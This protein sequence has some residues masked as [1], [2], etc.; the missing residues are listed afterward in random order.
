M[1]TAKA[2]SPARAH[3]ADQRSSKLTSGVRKQTSQPGMAGIGFVAFMPD[4][5]FAAVFD[6]MRGVDGPS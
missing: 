2:S 1:A 5:D 3:V 4:E 6:D